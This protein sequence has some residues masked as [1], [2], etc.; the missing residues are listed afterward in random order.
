MTTWLAHPDVVADDSASTRGSALPVQ[1]I[2]ER[3]IDDS[4]L[5]ACA[6]SAEPAS[7]HN[8]LLRSR[9]GRQV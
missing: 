4:W 5:N 6:E 7:S 9:A 1:F 2:E 3:L 8:Q